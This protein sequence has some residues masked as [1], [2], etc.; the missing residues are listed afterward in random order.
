MDSARVGHLITAASDDDDDD[1]D[2]LIQPQNIISSSLRHSLSF[3]STCTRVHKTVNYTLKFPQKVRDFL[4]T[5]K[6][7]ILSVSDFRAALA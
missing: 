2:R 7:D 4:H 5:K 3:R 1:D 6:R